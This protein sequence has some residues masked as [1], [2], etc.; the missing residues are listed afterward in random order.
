MAESAR[1]NTDVEES[2]YRCR[3]PL[4]TLLNEGETNRVTS[5]D[6]P[7]QA[8]RSISRQARCVAVLMGKLKKA[9]K[10]TEDLDN[11]TIRKVYHKPQNVTEPPRKTAASCFGPLRN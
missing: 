5:P 4:A 3:C 10:Q 1:M 7:R 6:G 11:L 8:H 9:V 2:Q